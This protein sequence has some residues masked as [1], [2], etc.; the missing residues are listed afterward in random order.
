MFKSKEEIK[1]QESINQLQ[2]LTQATIWESDKT[3]EIHQTQEPRGQPFSSRWLQGCK[4]QTRQYD[5][6]KHET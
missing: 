2:H 3:Q 1:D 4:E 5:K 6:D